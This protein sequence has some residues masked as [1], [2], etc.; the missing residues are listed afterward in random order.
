[1]SWA[2]FSGV[3]RKRVRSEGA[4]CLV[5]VFSSRLAPNFSAKTQGGEWEASS[6][7]VVNWRVAG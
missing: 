2:D 4:V 5:M 6:V 3:R 1:L 7:R